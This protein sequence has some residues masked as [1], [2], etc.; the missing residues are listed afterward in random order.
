MITRPKHVVVPRNFAAIAMSGHVGGAALLGLPALFSSGPSAVGAAF[1][2][3]AFGGGLGVFL[4]LVVLS[5]EDGFADD[6]NRTALPPRLPWAAIGVGVAAS[7][8]ICW[9]SFVGNFMRGGF[10]EGSPCREWA[11]DSGRHLRTIETLVPAQYTCVFSDGELALVEP[12]MLLALTLLALVGAAAIVWGLVR[13]HRGRFDDD[14]VL[15]RLAA[16]VAV[17]LVVDAVAGAI[18]LVRQ[19]VA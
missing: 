9:Q 5:S 18:V 13:L 11:G 19:G 2:G 16:A 4:G 7:V 12:S 15:R 8:V 6:S 1:C 17:F 10:L 14:W 3:A